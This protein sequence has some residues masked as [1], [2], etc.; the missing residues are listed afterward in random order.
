VNKVSAAPDEEARSVEV[1]AT[2]FNL[3]DQNKSADKLFDVTRNTLQK[4]K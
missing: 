3:M 4:V 2:H 1:G